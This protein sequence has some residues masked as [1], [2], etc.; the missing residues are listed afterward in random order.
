MKASHLDRLEFLAT[1]LA[2][3]L[4]HDEGLHAA[5][6]MFGLQSTR[7]GAHSSGERPAVIARV[8]LWNRKLEGDRVVY[9]RGTHD[10]W[11]LWYDR[12]RIEPKRAGVTRILLLGESAARGNEYAPSYAP[13]D[14]LQ[15]ILHACDLPQVEVLDIAR[16]GIGSSELHEVLR[17]SVA[18][19]P[20]A[21]VMF[22]GNNWSFRQQTDNDRL[23]ALPDQPNMW[24][25][26]RANAELDLTRTAEAIVSTLGQISRRLNIPAVFLIPE[27][28]LLDWRT[29][30]PDSPPLEPADVV[31]WQ[32]LLRTARAAQSQSD[33]TTAARAA[34]EMLALDGGTMAVTF[35]ILLDCSQNLST[36]QKRTLLEQARDA[37]LGMQRGYSPRCEKVVQDTL[38][39]T[40][41]RHGVGVIDLP[42]QLASVF[43]GDLPGRNLFLDNVHL[44][45]TGIRICM[46]L[47]AEWLLRRMWADSTFS[48]EQLLHAAPQPSPEAH[49]V[50]NLHAAYVNWAWCQGDELQQHYCQQAIDSYPGGIDLLRDFV[51]YL[52]SGAHST[53]CEAFRR[54]RERLGPAARYSL[55][56]ITDE[57]EKRS[58]IGFIQNACHVLEARQ[59][60]STHRMLARMRSIH[61]VSSCGADLLSR[62]LGVAPVFEFSGGPLLGDPR[63]RAHYSAFKSRSDFFFVCDGPMDLALAVTWR[64]LEQSAND[65]EIEL[66]LNGRRLRL[67]VSARSWQSLTFTL[68]SSWLRDG[69]N[70]VSLHW[71][72]PLVFWRDRLRRIADR[73]RLDKPEPAYP[74]YGQLHTLRIHVAENHV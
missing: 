69:I 42:E 25:A 7:V 38:R 50:A 27:F 61:G 41:A 12:E 2:H 55:E 18:L 46:A 62:Y 40:L 64:V 16:V 4:T 49:A 56:L 47:T 54:L 30:E 17:S 68:Q 43:D 22:A 48:F 14:V 19:E 29:A 45:G 74:A 39:D 58:A 5:R 28:N 21:I 24:A 52:T 3:T 1:R 37:G 66:Q 67:L 63:P 26:A 23:D 36:V 35:H 9:E 59:P 32:D 65:S 70:H 60:G 34:R 33:A 72:Q 31:R 71:P 13:A 11:R 53:L 57:R 15:A 51:E 10:G 6:L 20:D 8:G 44:N 73:V